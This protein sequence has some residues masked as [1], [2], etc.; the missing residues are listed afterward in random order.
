VTRYDFA[1]GESDGPGVE[2]M[3]VAMQVS[4]GEAA[5]VLIV[6]ILI[7]ALLIWACS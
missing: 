1:I 6:T 7:I 3:L 4:G 5:G 2:L